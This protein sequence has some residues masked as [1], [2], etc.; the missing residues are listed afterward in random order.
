MSSLGRIPLPVLITL[1]TAWY[2]AAEIRM[3]GRAV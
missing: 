1:S 3:L 2:E